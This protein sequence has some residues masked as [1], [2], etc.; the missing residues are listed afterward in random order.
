MVNHKFLI[1]HKTDLENGTGVTV[2][3]AK[4]GAIGGVSV[5][6][7]APGTR[8]TD[9]LRPMNT[10]QH[11]HAVVL[12]G[13]SAFGLDAASG[14]MN[15]LHQ[16]GVGFEAGSHIVPIVPAAVIFDLNYKNFAYPNQQM[17]Y[18]AAKHAHHDNFSQGNIGAGCGAT[19]GKILGPE[20]ASKGGL[21]TATLQLK[22]GVI[23]TAIMVVNALG[24]VYDNQGRF[25]TGLKHPDGLSTVDV[26]LEDVNTYNFAGQ[27]TTIGCVLTNAK[28]S[29]EEANKLA[30]IA[31]DGLALNIRPVHTSFDG[32]T[33]FALSSDDIQTDFLTLQT[34]CVQ[35]VGQAIMNAISSLEGLSS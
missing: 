14:V 30:D 10:V 33:I 22:D 13:G 3:L 31:H 11:V 15:Y 2:I 28:L 16:Q 26:L 6:G 8:E 25:L 5:R 12:A 24:D 17:G 1:G 19:V 21:G 23:I 29:K 9:L 4:D 18:E 7:A 32:D 34:A 20:Q 27:N 35:V